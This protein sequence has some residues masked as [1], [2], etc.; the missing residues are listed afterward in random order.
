M[1]LFSN[2]KKVIKRISHSNNVIIWLLDWLT[3]FVLAICPIL[4]HYNGVF[5]EAGVEMLILVFPYTFLKLLSRKSYVIKPILPLAVYAVYIAVVHGFSVFTFVREFLLLFYFIAVV[6]RCIDIKKYFEAAKTIALCAFCLIVLQYFT[7]YVLHFHTQLVPVGKLQESAYQWIGLA[8][9]GRISVTG[10]LMSIYRPSAFFLE[11]SHLA[12]YSI[13]ILTLNLLSMGKSSK[14]TRESLMLS[15]S[16]VLSTSGMG[17]ATVIAIWLVYITLYYGVDEKVIK[18][19]KD[20]QKRRNAIIYDI[21]F[22][23]LIAGIYSSVGVFRSA[24]NRIFFSADS[25]TGNAIQGRTDTGV[26]LLH[27]LSGMN[28]LIGRGNELQISDWNVSGFFY[29]VFQY[30]WIG[31]GLYYW[32]YIIGLFKFKREYFW[33]T[34]IVVI[35]SFFTVHT[36]AAFYRM[37][38]ICLILG[39]YLKP[40]VVREK[41]KRRHRYG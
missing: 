31:A 3:A 18:K 16:I 34:V 33:L 13:P 1:V 37:Y 23:I 5:L 20:M 36:F 7:Y 22:L 8:T 30:G 38:F 12:I 2:K 10:S 21:S 24:V 14:K 25:G 40:E 27:M 28:L 19:T 9:T 39:G 26:R 35:L 32:F 17:I 4:Q 11:P 6:N 29:T 15:G 41:K